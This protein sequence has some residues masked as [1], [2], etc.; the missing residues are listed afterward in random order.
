MTEPKPR[1]I[2]SGNT[3]RPYDKLS[4]IQLEEHDSGQ[5]FQLTPLKGRKHNRN[6]LYWVGLRNAVD[7]TDAWPTADHLHKAL[8]KAMGY[9]TKVPDPLTGGETDV[10]DSISFEKM[11]EAEFSRYFDTVRRGFIDQMGFD[12]WEM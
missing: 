9:K 2:K 7:A 11:N 3:L 4:G 12:P 10:E 8:K 5:V 6:S 1:V